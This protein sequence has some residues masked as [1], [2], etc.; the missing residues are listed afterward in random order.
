MAGPDMSVLVAAAP[1][2]SGEISA[3]LSVG[4][5][6]IVVYTAWK[7]AQFVLSA[8]GLDSWDG[9][10]RPQFESLSFEDHEYF[11]REEIV[12]LETQDYDRWL[13]AVERR[14]L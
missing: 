2:W 12:A 10:K 8:I 7:G 11:E 9:D 14:R 3:L 6:L 13:R 1:D 5:A 4:A